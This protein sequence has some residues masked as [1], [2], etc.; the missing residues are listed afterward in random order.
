MT[1]A[2]LASWLGH[3]RALSCLRTRVDF[4]LLV[5]CGWFG[6]QFSTSHQP[7]ITELLSFSWDWSMFFRAI[8]SV[9][10]ISLIA[11]ITDIM[12]TFICDSCS[13]CRFFTREWRWIISILWLH[14]GGWFVPLTLRIWFLPLIIL[15][16][17]ILLCYILLNYTGLLLLRYCWRH[18][19][20]CD[21]G[22]SSHWFLFLVACKWST[23]LFYCLVHWGGGLLA[24]VA[25]SLIF[26]FLISNKKVLVH[27]LGVIELNLVLQMVQQKHFWFVE[28]FYYFMHV[29]VAK[30]TRFPIGV[31]GDSLS[32]FL[33]RM[34]GWISLASIKR[35]DLCWFILL[36]I[37]VSVGAR[38]HWILILLRA[39]ILSI[40]LLGRYVT[41]V[42]I[43]MHV[44][45]RKFLK[46]LYLGGLIFL[47]WINHIIW[48][49]RPVRTSCSCSDIWILV[50]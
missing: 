20:R 23:L 35:G 9:W 17:L 39:Q 43:R 40:R 45:L 18:C 31:W 15:K 24:W 49:R 1:F 10:P 28:S 50:A 12:L 4:L 14:K 13:F 11:N 38:W 47:L 22:S 33:S 8:W 6:V 7:C 37:V 5:R 2:W 32:G 48:P 27:F 19:C 42:H 46:T 16:L 36:S 3:E 44:V 25:L 29:L 30:V 26:I 21:I 34:I 41:T